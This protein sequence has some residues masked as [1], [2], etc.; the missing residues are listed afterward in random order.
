MKEY[1]VKSLRTIALRYLFLFTARFV[2]GSNNKGLEDLSETFLLMS[3]L[4][5]KNLIHLLE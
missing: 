3:Q 4:R 2:K 1:R 5:R